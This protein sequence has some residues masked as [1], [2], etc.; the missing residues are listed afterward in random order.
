MEKGTTVYSALIKALKLENASPE[1]QDEVVEAIGVLIYQAVITRAMEEIGDDKLDEFEKVTDSDP[2]PEKLIEFFL[3][4]IPNFE[5]MM[6][7][8]AMKIMSDHVE[9][10]NDITK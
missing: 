10:M 1:K 2:T 4:N 7:E 3:K 6:H 8:E 5:E 9:M